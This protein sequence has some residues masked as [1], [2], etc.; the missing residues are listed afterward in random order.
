MRAT[1]SPDFTCESKA[2]D[3]HNGITVVCA[4]TPSER[5]TSTKSQI[6][7]SFREATGM[8]WLASKLYFAGRSSGLCGLMDG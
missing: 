8:G 4:R 2:E 5:M 1:T 6:V 7:K 3:S